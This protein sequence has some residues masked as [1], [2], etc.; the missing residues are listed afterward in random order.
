M[1]LTALLQ[2]LA[3]RAYEIDAPESLIP[4]A[5]DNNQYDCLWVE[6]D[7]QVFRY[8]YRERD[9]TEILIETRSLDAVLERIFSDITR[10]M[11]IRFES[12]H[13]IEGQDS[14]RQWFLLQENLMR[15]LKAEWGDNEAN[16]HAKTLIIAPFVDKIT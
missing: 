15:Q 1:P 10:A 9:N 16:R 6:A 8:M 3:L 7:H 5:F 12:E 14:R 4:L 2:E 11:A 13:R